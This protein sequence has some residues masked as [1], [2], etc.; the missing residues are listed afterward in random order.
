MVYSN[1]KEQIR[2][3]WG[4]EIFSNRHLQYKQILWVTR[5]SKTK[6]DF[7]RGIPRD[8]YGSAVNLF[9]YRAMEYY[10]LPYGVLSDKY[11]L[12]LEDE[13]LEYY[14][15][16]PSTLCEQDKIKLGEL[17]G[18]KTKRRGFKTLV[19]YNNSPLMSYPYFEMLSNSK[20]NVF[21]TTRLPFIGKNEPI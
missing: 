4:I 11:G 18:Q 13:K 19:I 8:L 6:N 14:D 16:H 21:F 20:L 15:I 7:K 1:W 12:H 17:I 3:R 2:K 10:R 5:C 9:F